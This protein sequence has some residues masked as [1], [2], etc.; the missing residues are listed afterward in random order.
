M[1]SLEA[2]LQIT[3]A[4]GVPWKAHYS[5]SGFGWWESRLAVCQY[6]LFNCA[7]FDAPASVLRNRSRTV[8]SDGTG[9]GSGTGMDLTSSSITITDTSP[10]DG[11][12][13]PMG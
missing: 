4:L 7:R 5:C 13:I 9:T 6:R 1:V 3:K 12:I 10:S 2:T 11:M 8:S